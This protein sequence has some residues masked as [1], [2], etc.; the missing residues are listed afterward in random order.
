MFISKPDSI[1]LAVP[2]LSQGCNEGPSPEKNV[3]AIMY[4]QCRILEDLGYV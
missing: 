3:M 1:L 2:S 4:K